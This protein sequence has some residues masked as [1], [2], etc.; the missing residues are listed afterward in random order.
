ETVDPLAGVVVGQN[1][2][3]HAMV[4]IHHRHHTVPRL[5]RGGTL[6]D[7]LEDGGDATNAV[8]HT[9]G[10]AELRA[11]ALVGLVDLALEL[12]DECLVD[13]CGHGGLDLFGPMRRRVTAGDATRRGGWP[14]VPMVGAGGPGAR[15][16]ISG[17]RAARTL[18]SRGRRT[19][20]R[21]R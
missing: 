21:D 17:D 13:G 18:R 19:R 12:L 7:L 5:R 11:L 15:V 9:D 16:G 2:L 3:H 8:L 14:R 20:G 4:D 6:A 1:G 10:G